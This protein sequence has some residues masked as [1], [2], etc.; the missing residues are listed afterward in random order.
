MCVCL[1][2]LRHSARV[3]DQFS[4][5][6]T[7]PER[8]RRFDDVIGVHHHE[9]LSLCRHILY[10]NKNDIVFFSVWLQFVRSMSLRRAKKKPE[11]IATTWS[12]GL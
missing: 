1:P 5:L 9:T 10:R 6:T 8:R 12:L 4:R 7:S 11:H 3:L 2:A